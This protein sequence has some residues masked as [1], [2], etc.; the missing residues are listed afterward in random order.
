MPLGDLVLSLFDH[1]VCSSE[2]RGRYREAERLGDFRL[3]TIKYLQATA[4]EVP[5]ALR[6]GECYQYS[7]H[8]CEIYLGTQLRRRA[9]H[10]LWR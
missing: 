3:T 1:L 8:Y 7:G 9:D 6:H 5:T 10:L 2:E 4:Q